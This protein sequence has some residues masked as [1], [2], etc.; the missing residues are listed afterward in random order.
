MKEYYIITDAK[1]KAILVTKNY[2]EIFDFVLKNKKSKIRLIDY[3]AKPRIL[4]RRTFL[5]SFLENTQDQE[6]FYVLAR[7]L[8][9]GKNNL[10]AFYI[11][12]GEKLELEFRETNKSVI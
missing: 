7:I 1:K 12:L 4:D 11:S 8:V 6:K 2:L 3:T 9:K 10:R 5:N